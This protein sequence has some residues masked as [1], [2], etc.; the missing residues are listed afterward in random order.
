MLRITIVLLGLVFFGCA[1]DNAVTSR[2]E[3]VLFT[4]QPDTRRPSKDGK[5]FLTEESL[6]GRNGYIVLGDIR[7]IKIWDNGYEP[8]YQE[9]ANKALEVGADAVIEVA[10]WREP[11]AASFA[12]PQ[13]SGKA[14][15]INQGVEIDFSKMKGRWLR[16]M[17]VPKGKDPYA[18]GGDNILSE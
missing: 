13:G 15:K 7:V 3:K 6:S 2:D 16:Y 1:Q 9:L 4:G 14:I 18:A 10:T 5:V 12:A 11:S 8:I 17:P